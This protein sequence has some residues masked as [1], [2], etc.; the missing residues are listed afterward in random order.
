MIATLYLAAYIFCG[1]CIV[2]FLLPRQS[3]L[4]RAW[5]GASLGLLL[6]MWLTALMAFAVKF[7][8]TGHLLALIPLTG[9]TVCTYFLRDKA[10]AK[11]WDAD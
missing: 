5:L 6:M 10:P 7:S 11:A 9:Q 4:T 8:V 1:L 2:R 3:V